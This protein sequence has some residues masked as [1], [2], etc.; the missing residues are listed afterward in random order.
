MNYHFD[1]DFD[2][3]PEEQAIIASMIDE[4]ERLKKLGINDNDNNRPS[5]LDG[6][7]MTRPTV[8]DVAERTLDQII[9]QNIII[10][11]TRSDDRPYAMDITD[12]E[13]NHL[14]RAN[15]IN[16]AQLQNLFTETLDE[17]NQESN[18]EEVEN[19]VNDNRLDSGP[20]RL[21]TRQPSY[22]V[23]SSN[24]KD[25]ARMSYGFTYKIVVDGLHSEDKRPFCFHWVGEVLQIKGNL[26]LN[27]TNL[28]TINA[29]VKSNTNPFHLRFLSPMVLSI[30]GDTSLFYRIDDKFLRTPFPVIYQT[31]KETINAIGSI[32]YDKSNSEYYFRLYRRLAEFPGHPLTYFELLGPTTKRLLIS[33]DTSVH[34]VLD[35]NREL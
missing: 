22:Y 11:H 35:Q 29:E 18:V 27:S 16:R 17:L 26:Y 31:N 2:I 34:L 4:E 28:V 30:P 6:I 1:P 32:H 15:T 20:S 5:K 23:S 10:R 19:L 8:N 25:I 13:T 9:S 14:I 33:I 12:D 21:L 3:T 7:P 24:N